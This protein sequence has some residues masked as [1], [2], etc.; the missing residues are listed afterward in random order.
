MAKKTR[1]ELEVIDNVKKL[2]EAGGYTQDDIAMF[3]GK[4]RGFVGQIESPN[5]ASKY[6]LNHLNKIAFEMG[7]SPKELMPDKAIE[8][9]L[10]NPE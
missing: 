10:S 1:F 2:R 7:C 5:S 3:I 6:N 8:E 4:T 9:D